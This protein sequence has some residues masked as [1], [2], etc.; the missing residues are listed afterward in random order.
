M[1]GFRIVINLISTASW[2]LVMM[3]IGQ[4]LYPENWLAEMS[5]SAAGMT[6]GLLVGFSLEY[7]AVKLKG[8][9]KT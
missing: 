3:M 9:A 7:L 8:M 4:K 5:F 1:K 2:L 6:F